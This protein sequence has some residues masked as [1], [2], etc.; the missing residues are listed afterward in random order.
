MPAHHSILLRGSLLFILVFFALCGYAQP[1]GSQTEIDSMKKALPKIKTDSVKVDVLNAILSFDVEADPK[2]GVEYG[3][4]AVA[5]AE[6]TGDKPGL[7]AAYN[8]LGSCYKNLSDYP[9]SLENYFKSLRVNEALDNKLNI[10]RNTANIGNIYSRLKNYNKALEYFNKALKENEALGR[11]I[12]ITNNLS[13][14]AVIY[15]EAGEQGKALE[16]FRRA[17]KIAEDDND[18]EGV[19]MIYANIGNVYNTL[20]KYDQAIENFLK[21]MELNEQLGRKVGLAINYNALAEMYFLAAMDT[22]GNKWNKRFITGDKATNLDRSIY[23]Y[24]RALPTFSEVGALDYMSANYQSMSQVYLAKKDFKNAYDAMVQYHKLKDSIFSNDNK[25]KLAN[26]TTKRAEFERK[27]QEK[28]TKLAQNKRRNENILFAIVVL[29][30]SIFT[31]F[32]IKERRKSEKLLLNILPEK[33]AKELK[34]K[35]VAAASSFDNV[36]VLFTDFVNFTILTEKMDPKV[37]VDE[38]HTC[39]KAFDDIMAKYEIEKIKTVGDAYIA[40]AGL[41]VADELHAVKVVNA[42]REILA[43][44]AKRKREMGDSTFDIRIGINSGSVVAGIVGVKKFAYD[45]WGDTVNTAARMEQNCDTGMIN[46]SQA[47]YDLVKDKFTCEY[48]GE[49]EA[50]NK[51]MLKMYYVV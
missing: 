15:S 25:V 49:I 40:V 50:K 46:I 30:F 16:Y 36:T 33:V 22:N 12:G 1:G 8:S 27:Q 35:G 18:Q 7:A 45:I 24:K 41:P 42:A 43:F 47:T 51:G 26:L 44:T 20:H 37:L 48:R 3:A 38:L 5:L 6:K 39:F 4:E 28:L 19:A 17:L 23:Y 11:K 9:K 13:G 31:A 2:E 10:A 34:E 32:V 21:S 29:L 14:I